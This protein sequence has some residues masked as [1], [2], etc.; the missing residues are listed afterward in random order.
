MEFLRKDAKTQDKE[1]N[2]IILQLSNNLKEELLLE[3][4]GEII[5]GMPMLSMNFG[6][7]VL[8]KLVNHIT[9]ARFN[10]GEII[11]LVIFI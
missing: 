2:E 3:A 11:Y 9:I 5:K 6:E 7:E 8:R 10:P 1:E 4:N